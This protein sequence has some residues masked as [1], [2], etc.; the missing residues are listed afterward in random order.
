MQVGHII[1]IVGKDPRAVN[2]ELLVT[3]TDAEFGA[4]EDEFMLCHRFSRMR[5]RAGI[6]ISVLVCSSQ[7][8]DWIYTCVKVMGLNKLENRT[9]RWCGG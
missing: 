5:Q 4:W 8:S 2:V 1:L 7:L 6:R 3:P 9:S